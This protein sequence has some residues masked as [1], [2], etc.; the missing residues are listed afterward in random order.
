MT[1]ATGRPDRRVL[2]PTWEPRRMAATAA[3]APSGVRADAQRADD[4][5]REQARVVGHHEA[6]AGRRVDVDTDAL[7]RAA[8][9]AV[10]P[11]PHRLAG[12]RLGARLVAAAA[13]EH[14][15]DRTVG[16]PG[17]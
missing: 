13:L 12:Q 10:A 11:R 5:V 6:E 3:A 2:E 9:D 17:P 4:Q 1:R 16:V 15:D 8:A 14:D 7:H